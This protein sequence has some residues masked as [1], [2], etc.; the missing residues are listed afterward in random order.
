MGQAVQE[1]KPYEIMKMEQ[2]TLR[3]IF[4]TNQGEDDSIGE[5]DL[6]RITLPSG[7]NTAWELPSLKGPVYDNSFEG[8]LVSW[9]RARSYWKEKFS[10]QGEPPNC[11]SADGVIGTGKP[12]GECKKCSLSQWIDDEPPKCTDQRILFIVRENNTL[13]LVLVLPPT[14][15]PVM[16][17][18]L[19]GLTNEQL[20]HW[21][22]VTRFELEKASSSEG[23]QYSKLRV[24]VVRVLDDNER[25]KLK[26]Y[27][28]L[29]KGIVQKT[30][31]T[32]DDYYSKS[33]EDSEEVVIDEEFE[34]SEEEI[35][36]EEPEHIAE[37]R[38]EEDEAERQARKDKP[39]KTPKQREREED[40]FEV[41]DKFLAGAEPEWTYFWVSC[42]LLEISRD[43]VHEYFKT[44][45]IK[46]VP[47]KMLDV[48]LRKNY[49]DK[50]GE[51]R[52]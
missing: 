1:Y 47:K 7:K 6:L 2:S 22:V 44:D 34:F 37:E 46:E 25:L 35:T 43:E 45:S 19:L 13:P 3:E 26:N 42:R 15:I 5:G 31:A 41:M 40:A 29:I 10:G 36:A 12:G 39:K 28:Y 4:D 49:A 18:Y 14:S 32:P 48:Y 16:R 11:R 23:I 52:L 9:K 30:H 50:M 20:P 33:N 17:R 27:V 24:S 38:H 8:I 21:S 51:P